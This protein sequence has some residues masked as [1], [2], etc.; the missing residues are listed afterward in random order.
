ME[1]L[2]LLWKAEKEEIEEDQ[3]IPGPPKRAKAPPPPMPPSTF[4]KD[5]PRMDRKLGSIGEGST[6]M[7]AGKGKEG[8][9]KGS[10]GEEDAEAKGDNKEWKKKQSEDAESS[11]TNQ[12]A[13]EKDWGLVKDNQKWDRDNCYG[14]WV[15]IK[16]KWCKN[17]SRRGRKSDEEGYSVSV[18]PPTARIGGEELCDQWPWRDETSLVKFGDYHDWTY[19]DIDE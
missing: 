4:L 10:K 5:N 19:G 14:G 13:Y 2:R 6:S 12:T 7:G 1:N 8:E 16:G 9:Q 17:Y 18:S 3:K 15:Q 11:Y